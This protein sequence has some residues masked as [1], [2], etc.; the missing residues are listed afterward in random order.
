MGGVYGFFTKTEQEQRAEQ[1]KE[2]KKQIAEEE[3]KA[4]EEQLKAK[5]EALKQE[6]QAYTELLRG[7]YRSV[8]DN[9]ESNL[10]N[11]LSTVT[12]LASQLGTNAKKKMLSLLLV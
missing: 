4:K 5:V 11:S 3:K 9:G 6:G 10:A 12:G 7:F 8:S 1:E 2:L